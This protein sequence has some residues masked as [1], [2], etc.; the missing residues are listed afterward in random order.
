MTMTLNEHEPVNKVYREDEEKEEEDET[1]AHDKQSV[2]A[3]LV[4]ESAQLK[5]MDR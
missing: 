5:S 4:T 1:R 2:V 3:L